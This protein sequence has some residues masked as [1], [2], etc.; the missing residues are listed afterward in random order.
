M[1]HLI[2]TAG[3]DQHLRIWDARHLSK[4]QPR[5]IDKIAQPDP[6][7]KKESEDGDV[8]P[9]LP[10]NPTS[11]IP[12]EQ[13]DKYQSSAKGKGLLRASY[14]HG[15]SCSSAYWDPWGRRI[16][17]TSYDDRLRGEASTGCHGERNSLQ[18]GASTP[19]RS[20]STRLFRPLTSSRPRPTL[21]TARPVAG[22]RFCAPTGH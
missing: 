5:A 11:S 2:V 1:P 16:L 21:T 20:C 13:V 6:I 19:S 10:T 7:V 14:Q 18:C 4:I 22:S 9:R 3:N 17:T 15:K 8:M 12:F